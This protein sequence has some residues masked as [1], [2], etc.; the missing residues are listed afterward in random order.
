MEP[1]PF[2][3]I[4]N[5][6]SDSSDASIPEEFKHFTSDIGK[7]E[8]YQEFLEP[9]AMVTRQ[10]LRNGDDQQTVGS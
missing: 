5:L 3:N 7:E 6:E 9:K 1:T 8:D 10:H 2:E 4:K